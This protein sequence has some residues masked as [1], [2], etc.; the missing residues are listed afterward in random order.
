M[1]T[2]YFIGGAP[3]SGKTTVI[4]RLV[5]RKPM[6]SASTDAVRNV[7]KGVTSADDRPKLHKVDRGEYDSEEHMRMMKSDPQSVLLHETRQSE[8]VWQSTLDFIGYYQRDGKDAAIEG[9][10]VLPKELAKVD[11]D[12]RAVFLVPVGDQTASIMSHARENK[13]DWLNKYDEN[14]LRS[15]CQFIKHWNNYY[16][17]EAR[18]YD[19]TVIE[20]NANNFNKGIDDAVN[21]LLNESSPNDESQR[22][23][24]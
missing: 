5:E 9:V 21:A 14:V 17:E 22:E 18:K 15:F 11:F 2:V 16:A 10:A 4:Q 24:S 7:A 23:V 19:F 12:Y 8:E 1:S 20:V 3:R 13:H 6:L